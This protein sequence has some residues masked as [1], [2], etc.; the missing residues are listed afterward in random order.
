[1]SDDEIEALVSFWKKQ[2]EPLYDGEIVQEKTGS[3]E[4]WNDDDELLEDAIRLVVE[5][6]QASISMLQ[7]RFRIGY[8]R[9]ARLIDMMELRGIVGPYQG[10]N[11]GKYWSTARSWRRGEGMKELGLS[12]LKPGQHWAFP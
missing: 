11:Q 10:A 7:R 12:Y 2:G 6:G 9:A 8:S 1:M 5:N 4:D 3:Q